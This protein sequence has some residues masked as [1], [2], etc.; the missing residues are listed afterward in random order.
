MIVQMAVE[1]HKLS[2]GNMLLCLGTQ[3]KSASQ[4][5][6]VVYI[7]DPKLD[8]EV[9]ESYRWIWPEEQITSICYKAGCGL[10]VS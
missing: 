1:E 3:A 8:F 2:G 7:L 4:S 6:V 9:L 10:I 5:Q